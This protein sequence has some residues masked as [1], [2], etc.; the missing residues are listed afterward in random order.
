MT[1]TVKTASDPGAPE[2]DAVNGRLC[3]VLDW[4][5]PDAGWTIEYSAGNARVYRSVNG[6]MLHVNHDSSG[7]GSTA[8]ATVRGCEGATTATDLANPYPAPAQV[9]NTTSVWYVGSGA[10]SRD[11]RLYILDDFF[12]FQC[13]RASSEIPRL[14]GNWDGGFFGQLLPLY[15]SDPYCSAIWVRASA[16]TSVA[17]GFNSSRVRA[18]GI[19]PDGSTYFQRDVTGAVAGSRASL[20]AAFSSQSSNSSTG[21]SFVGNESAFNKPMAGYQGRILR[22][23]AFLSC[24]G[25]ATGSSPGG[26][27]LFK[28]GAIPHLWC[29]LHSDSGALGAANTFRDAAYDP[30]AE[31]RPFTS[32]TGTDNP[33]WIVEETDTWRPF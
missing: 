5:L 22:T 29:P 23:P 20:Q 32:T 11:Y 7:S 1:L 6:R 10:G 15:D 25:A 28:R 12:I 33:W 18:G 31:F 27:A 24:S 26:S 3:A 13:V 21:G 2:L 16:S 4:A 14:G 19:Y 9:S 8:F 17:F 30:N